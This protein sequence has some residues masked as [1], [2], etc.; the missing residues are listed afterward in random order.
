MKIRTKV[1]KNA[2]ENARPVGF[3]LIELLV[4]IAII[5][6]LAGL[7]LP[8]LASAK[9]KA[10]GIQ[11][12]NNGKQLI[13]AS[14]LYADDFAGNWVPN[15]PGQP[16]WVTLTMDWS[17]STDNTNEARLIDPQYA[18]LAPYM[19]SPGIYHC[20][21]DKSR[22]VLGP[23]VRSVAMSQA[24]GTVWTAVAGH[25]P[26]SRVTGQWLTG[27]LDDSQNT[28]LTY[29][30]G[31][32]MTQPGPSSLWV[33]MDEHPNTINDS[34][35]AVQ[36]ANR[37]DWIDLPASYHNGACGIAFADGHSEIHKWLGSA[38]KKPAVNGG[39]H[40]NNFPINAANVA[41]EADLVWLQQRTSAKK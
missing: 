21:A 24:V 7:L 23:R 11:C 32:D 3:T 6:I 8:A 33:F 17:N 37:T 5:A 2:R 14:L 16:D 18:K 34:G 19:K 41:D 28:W 10:Q 30:R 1:L 29:G 4:V 22:T 31:T 40:I 12:L 26:G 36:C 13:L 38:V 20:P 39:P 27:S 15:Q 9:A 25:Q 35:L